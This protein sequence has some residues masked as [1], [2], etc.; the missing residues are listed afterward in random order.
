MTDLLLLPTTTIISPFMPMLRTNSSVDEYDLCC[1]KAGF[2]FCLKVFVFR[3]CYSGLEICDIGY[4]SLVFDNS[5]CLSISC[6]LIFSEFNEVPSGWK[7]RQ[8]KDNV[9]YVWLANSERSGLSCWNL[10]LLSSVVFSLVS[11]FKEEKD[12]E[13]VGLCSSDLASW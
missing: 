7:F 11:H 13:A 4:A 8:E 10:H 9:W 3:Y 2:S 5:I 12:R 6:L 1:G